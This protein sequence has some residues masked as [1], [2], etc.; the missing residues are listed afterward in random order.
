MID[1]RYHIVSLV[2]VFLALA[3]GIVLGAGP[4]REELGTTLE[5][6]VSELRDERALLRAELDDTKAR[7]Q[8]K[9]DMVAILTPAATADRLTDTRIGIVMLPGADR[10]M[11]GS[12]NDSV[13]RSGGEVVSTT[14]FRNEAE[15]PEQA[16]T[17][18]EAAVELAGLVDDPEPREGSE[19][20]LG[21]VLAA[22]LAGAD[23]PGQVGQW[24]IAEQR[25]E[26]LNFI[27]VDRDADVS[28]EAVPGTPD[29]RAPDA[30]V[31]VSG[32]LSQAAVESDEKGPAQL[33]ARM[34]LVAG[35]GAVDLPT[36]VVGYGTESFHDPDDLAADA[37]I[38]EIRKEGSV[39]DLVSTV[40]NGES[41]T[42]QAALVLSVGQALK[43]E[44]GQWG[45][46]AGAEG[47]GPPVPAARSTDDGAPTGPVIY[48][49]VE[50]DPPIGTDDPDQTGAATGS[51]APV[52][53]GSL[54]DSATA[55]ATP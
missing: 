51:D 7:D 18:H 31:V 9:D 16:A 17:R 39:A 23:E 24:P 41:A 55:T 25:L 36:V 1:F 48:P 14:W 32:G 6:Q 49:P 30:L 28:N 8:L 33:T 2:A 40:D 5:G 12:V 35:L 50:T 13:V 46:G 47:V 52:G 45:V 20:T 26:E 54:G 37:L 15:D 4:L 27:E 44:V 29:L 22:V 42:G 34:D 43:G 53:G 38:Q 19:P 10:N 3:V 11:L 21:T